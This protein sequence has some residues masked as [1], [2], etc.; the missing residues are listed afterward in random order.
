MLNFTPVVR[1]GYRIGVDDG[2]AWT[3][4]ANTDDERFGGSG[5]GNAQDR[6]DARGC[7]PTPSPAHGRPFSLSLTLPPLAALVLERAEPS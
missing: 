5:Q 1:E 6:G 3:E 7:R 2:G 4:L